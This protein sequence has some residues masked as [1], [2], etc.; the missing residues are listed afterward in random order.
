MNRLSTAE[1][2]QVLTALVEGNSINATCRMTGVAKM[3]VLKLL[4]DVGSACLEF[5]RSTVRGLKPKNVQCDEI[6]S[7]CYAKD[8]NLPE[9]MRDRDG[10]G[11]IWTWTAI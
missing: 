10:V 8:K 6:W 9:E 5:H 4:K 1:R 3:T 11:S 2:A 7:Y